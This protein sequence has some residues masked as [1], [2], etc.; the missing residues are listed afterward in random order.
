[1]KIEIIKIG[2]CRHPGISQVAEEYLKRLQAFA[3]VESSLWKESLAKTKIPKLFSPENFVVCLDE[4]GQQF[5]SITLSTNLQKWVNNSSLKRMVFVIG[6]PY[7][8]SDSERKKAQRVWSLSQCTSP[9][10]LS[11]LIVCEQLYR[12]FTIPK[13]MAYHHE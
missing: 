10:D 11:W 13:G 1:M 4:R 12:A 2:K 3:T 8:L 9:S 6:G 7:G 5:S